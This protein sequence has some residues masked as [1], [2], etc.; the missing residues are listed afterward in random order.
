[1]GIIINIDVMLAKRDMSITKLSQNVAITIAQYFYIE[2]WKA[3]A[4]DFQL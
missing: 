4:F 1:M 3:K 2:K